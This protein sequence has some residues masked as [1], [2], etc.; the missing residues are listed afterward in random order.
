MFANCNLVLKFICPDKIQ[1]YSQI[2][3]VAKMQPYSQIRTCS[4]NYIYLQNYAI[5]SHSQNE[6][7]NRILK[8]I[9][10]QKT[11]S[12]AILASNLSV[13]KCDVCFNLWCTSYLLSELLKKVVNVTRFE[14][15]HFNGFRMIIMNCP[16][17]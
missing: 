5:Q 12:F 15:F 4:K 2:H 13:I 7:C 9:F 6:R 14:K 17:Q 8:F 10:A 1:F 3:L 16:L 11:I